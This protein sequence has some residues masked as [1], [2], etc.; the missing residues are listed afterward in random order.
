MA[1]GPTLA[2][3]KAVIAALLADAGVAALVGARVYD[4]PPQAVV[5]PYVRFGAADQSAL[6]MDCHTDDDVAFA[7]ECH[8]RPESVA[9]AVHPR[10]QAERLAHAVRLALDQA[11]LTVEGHSLDWLDYQTQAVSRAGDG[12]SYVATVAF[13]AALAATP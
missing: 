13:F 7:V 3:R 5:F 6:R 2:L 11:D 1:D 4:E 12:R 9:Q 10:V 8:A